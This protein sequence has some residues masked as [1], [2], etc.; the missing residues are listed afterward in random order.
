MLVNPLTES[1]FL[2]LVGGRSCGCGANAH[3][4]SA[5]KPDARHQLSQW[6]R[7]GCHS[8]SSWARGGPLYVHRNPDVLLYAP[9]ASWSRCS[10][11]DDLENTRSSTASRL[12]GFLPICNDLGLRNRSSRKRDVAEFDPAPRTPEWLASAAAAC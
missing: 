7:L 4:Q 5:G 3:S 8:H 10:V 6:H 12:G 9:L 11:L 1:T 2:A